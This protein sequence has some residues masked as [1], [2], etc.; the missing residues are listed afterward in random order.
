VRGIG[1]RADVDERADGV[2]MLNDETRGVRGVRRE[3]RERDAG[4]GVRLRRGDRTLGATPEE[5]RLL[6]PCGPIGRR[7]GS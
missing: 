1:D 3:Q 5:E 7:R 6:G 2:G 4:R